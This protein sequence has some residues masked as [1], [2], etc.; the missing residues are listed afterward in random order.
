[1]TAATVSMDILMNDVGRDLRTAVKDAWWQRHALGGVSISTWQSVSSPGCYVV[2]VNST[3]CQIDLNCI[4]CIRRH[5][6]R[7]EVQYVHVQQQHCIRAVYIAL[8]A[9]LASCFV[10]GF[11]RLEVPVGCWY[12]GICRSGDVK[13]FGISKVTLHALCYIGLG[14]TIGVQC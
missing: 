4:D 13:V 5:M 7:H 10:K 12:A 11:Y 6:R 1:M 9:T 8:A 14:Y 3:P 2:S